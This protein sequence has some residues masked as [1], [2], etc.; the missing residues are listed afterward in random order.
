MAD[1][2]DVDVD[3]EG[4]D[5]G[6]DVPVLSL[7]LRLTADGSFATINA[8]STQ[9][10]RQSVEMLRRTRPGE[11]LYSETYGSQN[12]A[13]T[14]A[15]GIDPDAI[16]ALVEEQEPRVRASVTVVTQGDVARIRITVRPGEE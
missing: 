1:E 16:R 3:V 15:A 13:F 6:V 10:I 7:P 14:P 5:A 4:F 9:E 11:R 2:L 12:L 8:D